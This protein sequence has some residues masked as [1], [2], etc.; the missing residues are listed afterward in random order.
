MLAQIFHNLSKLV[1]IV[2]KY[3]TKT[4][5]L[6]NMMNTYQYLFSINLAYFLCKKN[7]NSKILKWIWITIAF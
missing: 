3:K 5:T 7:C 4:K 1:I 2:K 6:R